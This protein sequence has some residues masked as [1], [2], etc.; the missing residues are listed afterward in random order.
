MNCIFR[1]GVILKNILWDGDRGKS[2]SSVSTGICEATNSVDFANKASS[3]MF[4]L[5]NTSQVETTTFC[6]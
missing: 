4:L 6:S 5:R 3:T 1:S 2:V